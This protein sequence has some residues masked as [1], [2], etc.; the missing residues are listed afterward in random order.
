MTADTRRR[1]CGALV[2]MLTTAPPPAVFLYLTHRP[3]DGELWWGILVFVISP[4]LSG[5]LTG[6]FLGADIADRRHVKS[7]GGAMFTGAILA[8]AVAMVFGGI[9]LAVCVVRFGPGVL[10]A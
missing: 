9:C 3:W 1:V 8:L 2:W 4:A 7:V 10:M 6:W 5:A